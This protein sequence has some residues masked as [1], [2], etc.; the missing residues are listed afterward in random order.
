[1]RAAVK[2]GLTLAQTRKQVNLEKFRKQLAGNDLYRQR[3]FRDF[4]E[5]PG[6]ERAYKEAKGEPRME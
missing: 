2:Q 1:M 4:F 3:A 5:E 6:I